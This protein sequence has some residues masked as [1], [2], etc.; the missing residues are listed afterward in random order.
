M[1]RERR[2]AM[3]TGFAPAASWR[4]Q[5]RV[6]MLDWL[7]LA[8]LPTLVLSGAPADWPRWGVMWLAA[9]AI[10]VGCKWLSWRRSSICKAPVWRHVAYFVAWPGLDAE[11]FLGKRSA[12]LP[13]FA[14]FL[15]AWFNIAIG[16]G[17]LFASASGPGGATV[18]LRGWVGM[19]GLVLAI[20]FGLLHLLSCGW[21]SAGVQA[22]PLM[23]FPIGAASVSEFWGSRWNTAFRDFA[24]RFL[25]RPISRQLGPGVAIVL[26]YL[27]SGIIH[28]VVITV[29]AEGGYGGPTAYFLIQAAGLLAERSRLGRRIGLGGGIGGR[30]FTI[31]VVVG[32]VGMLFP[33]PFVTRIALPFIM[34][35]TTSVRDA[36]DSL[37]TLSLDELIFSAGIGQLGILTASALVPFR[38]NWREEFRSLSRL[39]R[40]MY[41]IY[42]GYVVLSIAA[43]GLICTFNAHELASGSG[44]ARAF[45]GYVAVFWGVRLALQGVLDVEEHLTRW[46]LRFGYRAL[47]VLF[48]AF[49]LIFAW[50]ALSP[51]M[52]LGV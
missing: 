9:F 21:R 25:F 8:T 44:L 37:P 33:E 6:A 51:V 19:V 39:H 43:F 29:P 15:A 46:W 11:A 32:P 23:R 1:G 31:A 41:W 28:D 2:N 18:L 50:S 20:H 12:S 13:S 27:F 7:L 24:H 14:E 34:A 5:K 49:T 48:T 38:L 40:Q 35:V 26:T 17:L 47:T 45:C 4:A 52:R 36:L 42:G 3:G 22:R 16:V 30:M 10:F